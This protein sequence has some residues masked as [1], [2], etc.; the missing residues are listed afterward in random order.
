MP[1]HFYRPVDGHGL[2]HDPFNA[3]IAPRPIGWIS[4]LTPEGVAN[5]APF[6][7]QL[8]HAPGY[9]CQAERGAGFAELVHAL[10]QARAQHRQDNQ[11]RQQ[12]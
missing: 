6:L 5:L 12:D 1:T 2:P 9:I 11:A 8:A 10:L 4:S 7:P 3:I